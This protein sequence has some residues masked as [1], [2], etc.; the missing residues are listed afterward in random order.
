VATLAVRS[1]SLAEVET[2]CFDNGS[3]TAVSVGR[4]TGS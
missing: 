4:Y 2:S 3:Q 1:P